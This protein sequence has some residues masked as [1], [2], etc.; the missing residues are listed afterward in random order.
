MTA[1]ANRQARRAM[2]IDQY[3]DRIADEGGCP[4]KYGHFECAL[5]V[6]GPCSD[7][8]MGEAQALERKAAS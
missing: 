7:E 3:L 2:R 6:D 5:Y 1:L 8:M 4:C